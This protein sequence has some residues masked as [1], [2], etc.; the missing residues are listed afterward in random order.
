MEKAPGKQPINNPPGWDAYKLMFNG[1]DKFNIQVSKF[2]W[3]YR[4]SHWT[5]HFDDI[6]QVYVALNTVAIW[7]EMHPNDYCG[8]TKTLL[9]KLASELHSW[10]VSNDLP[11]SKW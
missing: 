6:F 10:C 7:R 5:A 9:L 11:K 2:V 4:L 8:S 1:C 3:P